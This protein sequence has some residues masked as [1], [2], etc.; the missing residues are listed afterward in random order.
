V[1]LEL[2][3]GYERDLDRKRARRCERSGQEE[4]ARRNTGLT[5]VRIPLTLLILSAVAS[6]VTF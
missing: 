2:V 6:R 1:R 5:E 3:R 4:L